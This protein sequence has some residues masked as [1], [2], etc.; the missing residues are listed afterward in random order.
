MNIKYFGEIAEITKKTSEQIEL[1]DMSLN[2][3]KTYLNSTYKLALEDIH[4]AV[5][6]DIVSMYED[7]S[8]TATDEIAILSPF[9][10]G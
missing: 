8:L 3:L 5:N 4:I 7:I 1:K 9:A 10:G 2:E 6:H